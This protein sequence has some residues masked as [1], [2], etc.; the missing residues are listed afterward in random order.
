MV[1]PQSIQRVTAGTNKTYFDQKLNGRKF[2]AAEAFLEI[3]LYFGPL[4]CTFHI[5]STITRT[6]DFVR[7]KEVM[8]FITIDSLPGL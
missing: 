4:I 1:T 7:T 2:G 8:E 5:V 6:N 3:W